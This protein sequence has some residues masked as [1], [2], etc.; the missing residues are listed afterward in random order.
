[1]GKLSSIFDAAMCAFWILT[2]VLAF[3]GTIRYRYPLISPVSQFFFCTIEFAML[4]FVITNASQFS[5]YV[6]IAYGC[7]VLL[8]IAVFAVIL[9]IGFV[10]RKHILP[11]CTAVV[12]V[13][14]VLYFIIAFADGMMFICYF[15][16]LCGVFFWFRF[17][18]RKEY[19]MKPIALA[20]FIL[21][22]FAD[23]FAV[24]VYLR[25]GRLIIV[26]IALLLPALDFAFLPVYCRGR[27]RLDREAED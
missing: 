7:W 17:I 10:K 1:M 27:K 6:I 22:L 15:N 2:Y 8:E 9:K 18:R 19:P 24:P 11:Y 14:V 12:V 4:L 25:E 3:I 21:K 13:S 5:N 20:V 26:L 16:A 23:L